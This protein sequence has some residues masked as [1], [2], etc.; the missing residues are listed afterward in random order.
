VTALL[1]AF[2][3]LD[4]VGAEILAKTLHPLIGKTADHNLTETVRF[5]GQLSRASELNGPGVERLAAKLTNVDPAVRQTFADYAEVVYQ[6]AILRQ[7]AQ[8]VPTPASR[9]NAISPEV[10]NS[11]Y[12][13]PDAAG[14]ALDP[15]TPRRRTPI[16]RR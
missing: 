4:N 14:A 16:F 13:S 9:A 10:E 2:V 12:A 6:R 11:V 5:I 1:D 3:D 15:I 8:A 7:A